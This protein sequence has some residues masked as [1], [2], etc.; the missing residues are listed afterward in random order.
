MSNHPDLYPVTSAEF[1]SRVLELSHTRPVLVDFWA[2]WCGPCRSIAPLLEQLVTQ[3]DGKLS[4][5]KVDTD[6]EAEL[7]GRYGVRSLPTLAVFRNGALA[8]QVVGAQPLQALVALVSR[9]LVRES[10]LKAEEARAALAAGSRDLATRLLAEAVAAD[11]EHYVLYPDYAACLIDSGA[12]DEAAA[13]MDLVPTRAASEALAHQQ[14][15]L[16]FARLASGS[17]DS[18]TLAARIA[19]GATDSDARFHWAVQ[20]MMAGDY[21]DGLETLLQVV[22]SDRAY[23]EDAA[24]KLMLDVFSLL[25]A[26]DPLIREYR[27]QLARALN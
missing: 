16:R 25:P 15:R 1:A 24:R 6:A 5:A 13:V 12:L 23:G 21:A 17:A 11:P 3:F 27:S 18:A 19:S 26:G 8:E 9:H 22:R 7:A 10:D 20:Q 2:A 14:A 4:V